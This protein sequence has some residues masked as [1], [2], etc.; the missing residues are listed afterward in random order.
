MKSLGWM[1]L[2][3]ALGVVAMFAVYETRVQRAGDAVVAHRIVQVDDNASPVAES[4]LQDERIAESAQPS[5]SASTG[6]VARVLRVIDGDTLSVELDGKPTT[7]RLI[8]V[9]TPETVHP[10]RP[11]E[12]YGKEASTFTRNLLLGENVVLRFG[13]EPADRFGRQLAY[14]Y[15]ASDRLFVNEEIIRQGY[16]HA[17]TRF[18]FE[19]MA[20]FRE[21]ERQAREAGRG[22]W[23]EQGSQPRESNTAA[24]AGPDTVVYVSPSGTKYHRRSCRLLGGS[25]RAVSLAEGR[26]DRSPCAVCDPPS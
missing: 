13:S 3:A 14:V 12:A 1:L 25:G 11:V 22:L 7:V 20:A 5:P 15:R 18:P 8:G 17:Y 21:A 2:G 23:G 26:K 10:N 4:N 6:T 9:D 24:S 19:H 16:G